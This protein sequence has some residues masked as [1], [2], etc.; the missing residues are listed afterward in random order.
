MDVPSQAERPGPRLDGRRPEPRWMTLADLG[1]IVAGVALVLAIPS[2]ASGWPFFSPRR[3]SC[4]LAVIGGLRLTMGFGLVLALV[5]LFRRGR[6]GGPVRPAEWLA[7]GLA[8]LR[9]LDGGAQPRRG[10]QRLLRRRGLHRARLRRRALAAVRAGGRGR[11]PGRGGVGPPPAS[12]TRRV[13]DRLGADGRRDRG[14]VVPLVLGAV[15][16]RPPGTAVAPGAGPAGG[17]VVVGLAGA[18]WCSRFAMWWRTDPPPS[19]G[20]SRPPPRCGPGGPTAVAGGPGPGSGPS[21]PPSPTP[22]WPPCC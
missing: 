3:R 13:A 1:V 15:R 9:L 14:R 16:G 6:Y 12:G 4:F 22:S 10:G 7:L 11:R 18:R 8:S 2:R 19:P 17:P 21:G 20:A 5:V